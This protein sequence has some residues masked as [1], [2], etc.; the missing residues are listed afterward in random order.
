MLSCW[1]ELVSEYQLL[2]RP[3]QEKFDS[4]LKDLNVIRVGLMKGCT[5]LTQQVARYQVAF[6]NRQ[7]IM[8]MSANGVPDS[9]FREIF[10][11][12]DINIKGMP[13]RVQKG[14][15]TAEDQKYMQMYTDVSRKRFQL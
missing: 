2:L 13:G 4:K 9:L 1:P 6:L 7:F 8:I 10:T 5:L 14:I 15:L 3:S 12:A 11:A